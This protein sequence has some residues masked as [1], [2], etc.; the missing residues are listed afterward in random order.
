MSSAWKSSDGGTIT[1]L[2]GSSISADYS[3]NATLIASGVNVRGITLRTAAL[4][5][6][7]GGAIGELTIGG[8]SV[9]VCPYGLGAELTREIFIPAGLAVALVRRAGTINVGLTYDIH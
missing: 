7:A 3:A 1:P 6:I 2:G 4:N 9:L 5:A 8:V